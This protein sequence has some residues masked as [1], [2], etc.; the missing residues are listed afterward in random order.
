MNINELCHHG[1]L[2]Q[3]WGVRRFQNK[4]GSLTSVG[5]KRYVKEREYRNKMTAISKKN[6]RGI[7]SLGYDKKLADYRKDNLAV[8][9]SKIASKQIASML[10]MD[11]LSGDI[12]R[13]S[14][15]TKKE[16]AK[17]LT[18]K[19]TLIAS[20]TAANVAIKDAMAKSM[21]K[22]YDSNGKNITRT[23][24]G[25]LGTKEQAIETFISAGTNLAAGAIVVA[26]MKYQKV[27]HDR[28]INE[29]RFNSFAG[30]VLSQKVDHVIWQSDDRSQYITKD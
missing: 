27:A 4:N 1:I 29:Q 17:K 25:L 9:S 3:K 15:L 28:Y 26:G 18:K 30:K 19:A 12:K 8:R 6:S 2:G 21:S 20:S 11:C 7:K 22:R 10:I 16:I 13:Y 23:K 14:G 24:E 5:R